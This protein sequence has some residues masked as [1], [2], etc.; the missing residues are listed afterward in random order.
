MKGVF[1]LSVCMSDHL[2][3]NVSS[4]CFQYTL[5]L[6]SSIHLSRTNFH[7]FISILRVPQ[8]CFRIMLPIQQICGFCQAFPLDSHHMRRLHTA[9]KLNPWELH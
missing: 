7:V 9:N 4:P 1:G 6:V 3:L 8:Y 5:G 2:P